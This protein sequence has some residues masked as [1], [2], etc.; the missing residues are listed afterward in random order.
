MIK[1]AQDRLDEMIL[2][3]G[4][5]SGMIIAMIRMH[6]DLHHAGITVE[7]TE[8][9]GITIGTM[10]E[11]EG[12]TTKTGIRNH[13]RAARIDTT[14]DQDHGHDRQVERNGHPHLHRS[15]TA[16]PAHRCLPKKTPFVAS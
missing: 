14:T 1:V 8:T 10:A 15:H 6:L 2:D 12:G 13:H 5:L 3:G 16:G 4:A 11:R 7:E 9:R